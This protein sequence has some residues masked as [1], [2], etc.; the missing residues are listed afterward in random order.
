MSKEKTIRTQSA[1]MIKVKDLGMLVKFRLTLT[2]VFSAFMA[3]LIA[4]EGSIDW[5]SVLIL[6][7]GGFLITGASNTLNQVLEKDFDKLM[8]RTENRP[9]ATGRMNTSEAVLWAGFM[10]LAGIMLLAYFNVWAAFFGMVALVSYAFIYTPMKRVSPIAIT[11]GAFPGAL[12]VLI[13]CVAYQGE[14]TMLGLSLFLIQFLWQ[15]PH[16]LAIG[17]LGFDDYQKAGY[18]LLPTRNGEREPNTGFHSMLYA[19]LLIPFVIIPYY[20][21]ITGMWSM[22]FAVVVTLIY[23]W[24]GWNLQ[25]KKD[26]KS[27]LQ[28]MFSSFFYLPFI[29]IAFLIDK[30]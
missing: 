23:T 13:G 27:A 10:T 7:S 28:L 9:L 21:G 30:V 11:I 1:F 12:P 18:Q 26:R 8:A 4:S 29:L 5:V 16:F 25:Q 22:I 6:V 17:W 19:V 2:V 20:Y 3:F 24:F 15:F 14:L